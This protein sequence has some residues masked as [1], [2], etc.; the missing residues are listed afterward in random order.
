MA[1]ATYG[2]IEIE[3]DERFVNDTVGALNY[4]KA[5]DRKSYSLV[6]THIAK[7][8]RSHDIEHPAVI[9]ARER[10]CLVKSYSGFVGYAEGLVHEVEHSLLIN[11]FDFPYGTDH[12]KRQQ[13]KLC[14]QA[15]N[16]FR[17]RVDMRPIDVEK[18]LKR[19]WWKD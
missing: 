8:R 1:H 16:R 9:Y 14:L 19:E 2:P 13:E 10:L 12:E 18:E 17:R 5:Y 3:G 4:L 11:E 6:L 7:I 15:E